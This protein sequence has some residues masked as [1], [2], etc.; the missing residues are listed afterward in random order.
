MSGFYNVC[1]CVYVWVSVSM[2]FVMCAGVCE[3]IL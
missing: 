3:W 2:G 1:V